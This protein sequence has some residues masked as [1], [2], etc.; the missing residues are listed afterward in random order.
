MKI[1]DVKTF[2]YEHQAF[3]KIYTD[4]GINGLGEITLDGRELT[5]IKAIEHYTPLLI[6]R[7][8]MDIEHIWQMIYRGS[9]WRGGPTLLTALSGVDIALWD[10][11]GK[12]LNTP[13]YNLLGGK[14]RERIIAYCHVGGET[15]EE[16]IRNAMNRLEQGYKILRVALDPPGGWHTPFEP[17]PSVRRGVALFK[18]LREAVGEDIEIITDV[19]TRLSPTRAIEYCN[20]IAEYRPLFVEDPI[21]SENPK[22]FKYLRSQTNVPLATG[23]QLGAKWDFSSIIENDWVDYIRLDLVRSG[24][25][26]E[27]RKIAA[28]AETHY[29]EMALHNA[30]SPVCGMSSIHFC[31]AV[32]NMIALEFNG[33]DYAQYPHLQFEYEFRDGYLTLSDQPGLGIELLE[34]NTSDAFVMRELPHLRREDGSFQDW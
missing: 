5:A 27:G 12:A 31:Y 16:L 14:V 30:L 33:Y 8:P 9:F 2:T 22:A 17:G 6:G 25:F 10:I 20:A 11:K 13:V 21:R 1:I 18:A 26:T 24:G 3:V 28:M 32:P 29:Q 7:N 23:E 15:A 19:H 34:D 4:E